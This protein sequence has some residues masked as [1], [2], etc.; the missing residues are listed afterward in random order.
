MAVSIP[1][2]PV[3]SPEAFPAAFADAWH[4]RDGAHIAALFT[5]DADFVNV[6][7]LWWHGQDAIARPHDYA[8][9][10]FFSGTTLTPGRTG[11]R[12]L[13]P[14]NAVVR[15]RFR[16]TGQRAP[17]GS[18]G[19]PRQTILTFVLCRG[20]SGW[21]AVSA[22]NTDVVPGKETHVA[23]PDGLTAVDYRG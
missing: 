4:S 1:T 9:K 23:G 10:S 8:L 3:A 21:L 5:K 7:G 2:N 16:L 19:G 15:C 18:K 22:Q 6:T 17:D 14:D 12:Y 13:G 20:D 11:I